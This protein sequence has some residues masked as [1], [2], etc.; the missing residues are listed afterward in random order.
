MPDVAYNPNSDQYL[1]VFQG[2]FG[3]GAG[4]TREIYGQRL[5]STGVEIP[6]GTDTK[7]TDFKSTGP[8][9]GTFIN[10]ARG[11]KVDSLASGS[12]FL[13]AIDANDVIGS[14]GDN[15]KVEVYTQSVNAAGTPGV[16]NEVSDMGAQGDPETDATDATIEANES[17]G[18]YIVGFA[19]EQTD[20][21]RRAWVQTVS[22]AGVEVGAEVQVSPDTY[23]SAPEVSH[24]P[25]SDEYLMSWYEGA[26]GGTW[27]AGR[28]SHGATP[29]GG[30]ISP[31]GG[32]ASGSRGGLAHAYGSGS[33]RYM[34]VYAVDYDDIFSQTVEAPPA[35]GGPSP[36]CSDGTDNDGDGKVD[37]P[38]DP[39]CT[40]A[41]DDDETDP[42]DPPDT[43]DPELKL[44]GKKKQSNK[45]K[46]VVKAT[47]DEACTVV[48]KPKGKATGQDPGPRLRRQE[49]EEEAEAEDG[50]RQPQRRSDQE[51]EAQVQGQQDQET[52]QEG[53]PE[54]EGQDQA[55]A[56]RARPPMPPA[57]GPRRPSR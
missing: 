56:H 50:P 46:V 31:G 18:Q 9:S 19:G 52:G 45:K 43:T 25:E 7:Y 15:L 10:A 20:T 21:N 39:G 36:Q 3:S 48:V 40:S 57:T 2:F 26:I 30:A 16:V 54:E 29:I 41:A 28:F 35:G 17:T 5:S 27:A 22:A 47:C 23:S 38:A 1:V 4:F 53:A 13:L 14:G 37:F 44:K 42:V 55:Q 6:N 49:D 11:V 34:F 8:S 33:D 32:G 51:A 12:G 24:N